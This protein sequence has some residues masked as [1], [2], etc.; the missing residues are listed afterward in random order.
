MADYS[1][2]CKCGRYTHADWCTSHH[3]F[4]KYQEAVQVKK[5]AV[6]KRRDQGFILLMWVEGLW[7][8]TR[9]GTVVHNPDLHLTFFADHPD[10]Q[11]PTAQDI[12]DAING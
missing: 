6:D 2:S 8:C 4:K 7:G 3:N 11:H 12:K 9:C 5:Q 1:N 10:A